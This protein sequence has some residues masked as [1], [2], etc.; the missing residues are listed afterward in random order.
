MLSVAERLVFRKSAAAESDGGAPTQAELRRAPTNFT[1][2]ARPPDLV[3]TMVQVDEHFDVLKAIQHAGFKPLPEHPDATPANESLIL[4]ELFREAHRTRQGSERGTQFL[5]E[6][7]K[8]ERTA[9]ELHACLKELEINPASSW[10]AAETAFQ[11]LA[12]NCA[13]CH[14][15]HRN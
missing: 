8:A 14:K 5:V 7:A 6:L 1:S 3:N 10:H 15:T 12:K 4:F 11:N 9:S 13:A 2:R